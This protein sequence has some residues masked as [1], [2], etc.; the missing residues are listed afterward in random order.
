MVGWKLVKIFAAEVARQGHSLALHSKVRMLNRK[1][2]GGVFM[3]EW[4]NSH[5]QVVS[6]LRNSRSDRKVV[7]LMEAGFSG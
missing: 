3:M 1:G 7:T 4:P 6:M 5:T 2:E